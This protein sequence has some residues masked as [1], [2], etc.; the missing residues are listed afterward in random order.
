MQLPKNIKKK[1]Y[2]AF[3]T[4]LENAEFSMHYVSICIQDDYISHILYIY[5]RDFILHAVECSERIVLGCNGISNRTYRYFLQ[6]L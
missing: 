1:R 6:I 4:I 3:C 5:E 2:F